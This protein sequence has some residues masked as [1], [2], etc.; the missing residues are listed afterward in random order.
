[1][2][3]DKGGPYGQM[4]HDGFVKVESGENVGYLTAKNKWV[5]DGTGE[6]IGTDVR[7]I[8]FYKT[9]DGPM[10]DYNITIH[11]GDKDMVFGDDKDGTM[12][13]G[14][15]ESMRVEQPKQRGQKTGAAGEGHI[16][17]SAGKK[18]GEAWGTRAE[19]CDYYGPVEGKTAGI[20]MFDCP[21]NPRHPT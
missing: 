2:G 6:V 20:A 8:R 3:L 4:V 15:P 13:I 12:A 21:T 14:V 19:W 17:T 7:T 1:T 11:A 9:A 18:D 16:V 5:V 10:I